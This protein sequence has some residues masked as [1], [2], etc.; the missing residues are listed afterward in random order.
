MIRAAGS[1]AGLAVWKERKISF[2]LAKIDHYNEYEYC[3]ILE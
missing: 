1:R 3:C 2:F